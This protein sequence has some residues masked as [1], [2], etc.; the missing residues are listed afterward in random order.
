MCG[1][2]MPMLNDTMSFLHCCCCASM[3]VDDAK[4]SMQLQVFLQCDLQ[5]CPPSF[6]NKAKQGSSIKKNGGMEPK[7]T[8]N[9]VHDNKNA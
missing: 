7:N 6:S 4:H 8:S 5:N 2:S 3:W 1:A 9:C